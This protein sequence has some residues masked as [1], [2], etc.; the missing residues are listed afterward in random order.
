MTATNTQ[1]PKIFAAYT[2]RHGRLFPIGVMQIMGNTD[3]LES[4]LGFP[5]KELAPPH[6]VP[7][8]FSHYIFTSIIHSECLNMDFLIFEDEPSKSI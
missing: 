1:P 4:G 8:M 7:E 3:F 5:L 6:V 2:K